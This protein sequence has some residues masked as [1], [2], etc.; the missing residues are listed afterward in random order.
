MSGDANEI[1][2][3]ACF[4]HEIKYRRERNR[5]LGTFAQ[6]AL[7]TWEACKAYDHGVTL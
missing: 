6:F 5:E 1:L 2:C 4:E 3:R 7:P